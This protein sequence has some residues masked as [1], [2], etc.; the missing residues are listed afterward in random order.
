MQVHCSLCT[1]RTSPTPKITVQ[2]PTSNIQVWSTFFFEPTIPTYLQY[3]V[4][5]IF[6]L[7]TIELK[8]ENL[9]SSRQEFVRWT[10][11]PWNKIKSPSLVHLWSNYRSLRWQCS[12]SDASEILT[13][14]WRNFLNRSRRLKLCEPSWQ[15]FS[16]VTLQQ[17]SGWGR[18]RR[19]TRAPQHL[20]IWSHHRSIWGGVLPPI[21]TRQQARAA[22][23]SAHN[24]ASNRIP[25]RREP[26]LLDPL[27]VS[28]TLSPHPLSPLQF[29]IVEMYGN[30]W[31]SATVLRRRVSR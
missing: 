14:R 7:H 12:V 2:T 10:W 24:K 31:A 23:P 9:R 21:A 27:S 17:V 25:S 11:G 8:T 1:K 13:L 19:S 4:Q 26:Q 22:P 6:L 5:P 3:H 29:E 16:Q 28:F 18:F 15:K 30:N 20:R